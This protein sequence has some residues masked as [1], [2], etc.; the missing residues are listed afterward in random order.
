VLLAAITAELLA[1]CLS[2]AGCTAEQQEL[3]GAFRWDRFGA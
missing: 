2:N 1:A 3:L